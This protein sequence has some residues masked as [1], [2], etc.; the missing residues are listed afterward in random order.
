MSA[1]RFSSE[2]I[3]VYTSMDQETES[4]PLNL[5]K[6]WKRKNTH[7]PRMQKRGGKEKPSQREGTH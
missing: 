1:R 5:G 3:Y 2:A 7:E 4:V 6:C